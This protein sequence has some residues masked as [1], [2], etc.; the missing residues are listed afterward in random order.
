MIEFDHPC[1]QTCSGWQQGYERG[2]FDGT[3]AITE[4]Y[5]PLVEALEWYANEEHWTIYYT[6]GSNG[7]Y[8]NR[9]RKAL[10]E[11][12]EKIGEGE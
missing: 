6:E 7:D 1:K 2:K 4:L 9:A 8:G 5:Q 3:K 12:K 10:Q 11:F